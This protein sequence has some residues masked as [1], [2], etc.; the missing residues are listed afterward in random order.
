MMTTP[1]TDG[2]SR[3]NFVKAAVAIGGSA[4]LTACLDR[5]NP[6]LPQGSTGDR[7]TRQHAWNRALRT[8]EHGNDVAPRHQTL[9]LLDYPGDGTPTED[10]RETVERA[11]ET[12]E[13]AYP[14]RHETDEGERVGLVFTTSYSR[15]YF[16]RFADP[17]PESVDLPR[18][19]ALA[20]FEDPD[21]DEPDAVVHLASDYGSVV[22][23]AEEAL[24]GNQDELNGVAVEAA[25]T[26][27]LEVAERRTGFIGEGLPAENQDVE[28]IPD[29][30]PVDEDSPLYMGFKSG[31]EK[32][33]ATEDRVTIEK[34]P[35]AGGSTQHVSKI[36]L[37]LDQWYEQDSRYHREA[38]MFCPVHA[39]EGLVEGVGDNLGDSSK[40]EERG[41]PA[42]TED[43]AREYGT[44]GHSQKAA[45]ARD[46]D[47]PIILRRDFDATDDDRVTLHFVALQERIE[48]FVETREQMNGT[49]VAE[50]GVVGQRNNNGI[51]Q[52]MNV[53]RRGN[54]LVPPRQHRALPSPTPGS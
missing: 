27:V 10:N 32:N 15:A 30:E 37:N 8:D 11:L 36:R 43:H 22:L 6:E 4:A 17:L 41:C 47:G 51:L 26:D 28:G 49:D 52:Y 7:P 23:A 50:S 19:E 44:V 34:G 53:E 2:L 38:T 54:F 42:H 48:D 33:Q 24:R 5:E 13:R 9:L 18:P 1:R 46:D 20:P 16:E 21:P 40:M 39:E 12:L 29:S 14:P 45:R 35:F 31:F 25:L 3:R